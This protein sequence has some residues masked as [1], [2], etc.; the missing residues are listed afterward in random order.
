MGWYQR[1]LRVLRQYFADTVGGAPALAH[2][3]RQES[4]RAKPGVAY[5]SFPG[6]VR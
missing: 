6:T 5:R 2:V 3:N 4:K 1:V